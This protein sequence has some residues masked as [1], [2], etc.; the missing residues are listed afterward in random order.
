MKAKLLVGG[1]SFACVT[2]W[3]SAV[4]LSQDKPLEKPKVVDPEAAMKAMWEKLGAPGEFHKHLQ[5]FIGKW[6]LVVKYRM[7]PAAE[8]KESL[9]ESEVEWIIGDRF[10]R[11]EVEGEMEEG[12]KFE[13]LGF[14]GY[15]NLKKK[16][17]SAWMDNM[18]TGMM[19]SEG[20]CD[21]SGKVFTFVGEHIDPM[22][23]KAG[24]DKT[25][26]KIVNNDKHVME[27]YMNGPDGKEFLAMEIVYTR[28]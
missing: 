27:M 24:K 6:K 14:T 9:S 15:D 3:M 10:I 1:V 25:V 21:E 7:D 28:A 20:S 16:Y 23:G 4:A 5:P 2:V 8:W 22:T 17:V 19:V 26:L 18:G 12:V 13:G 11:E